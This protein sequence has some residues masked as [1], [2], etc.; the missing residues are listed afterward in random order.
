MKIRE[1]HGIS[2]ANL[3]F[4]G[5]ICKLRPHFYE[6][7]NAAGVYFY[8]DISVYSYGHTVGNSSLPPS[9]EP[10]FVDWHRII[11]AV[12]IAARYGFHCVEEASLFVAPCVA[13][14]ILVPYIGEYLV[15][16][17]IPYHYGFAEL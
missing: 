12:I 6:G 11:A 5:G 13:V 9:G 8:G 4:Y 14:L 2:S 3:H 7:I 1:R 15:S 17:V 10:P 16:Q